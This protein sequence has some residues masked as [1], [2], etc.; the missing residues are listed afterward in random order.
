M[1]LQ[2]QKVR[3]AIYEHLKFAVDSVAAVIPTTERNPLHS[4]DGVYQMA[5]NMKIALI[6]QILS[7]TLARDNR[8]SNSLIGLRADQL[9][10]GQKLEDF[11]LE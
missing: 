1:N 10:E 2:D 11:L 8:L 5:D 4:D 3:R 9:K 7:F 6:G